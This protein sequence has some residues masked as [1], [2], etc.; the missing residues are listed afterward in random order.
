MAL[1]GAKAWTI[2]L[3]HGPLDRFHVISVLPR[4]PQFNG[5]AVN[6]RSI[7]GFKASKIKV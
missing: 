4:Q 6:Q 1:S 7:K 5:I 3:L 2:D